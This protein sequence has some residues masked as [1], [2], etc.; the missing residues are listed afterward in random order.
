MAVDPARRLDL[1]V[2][3]IPPSLTKKSFLDDFPWFASVR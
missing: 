1:D 2:H 3:E